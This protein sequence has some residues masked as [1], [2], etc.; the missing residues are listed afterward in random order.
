MRRVIGY[1]VSMEV[2]VQSRMEQG[3]APKGTFV[4]ISG[5]DNA[6]DRKQR[7][8]QRID[9]KVAELVNAVSEF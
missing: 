2:D 7:A 3:N 4:L 8:T 1:D 9:G 5:V 6:A